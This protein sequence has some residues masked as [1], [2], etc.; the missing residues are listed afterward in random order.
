MAEQE[1]PLRG[2]VRTR[3]HPFAPGEIVARTLANELTKQLGQTV[4]VDNRDGAAGLAPAGTPREVLKKLQQGSLKALKINAVAEHFASNSAV[5]G[6]CAPEEFAAFIAQ[7]QKVW[8]DIVKR[9]GI[10]PD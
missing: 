5:G 9:A 4:Y 7:P 3:S 8:A 1:H 2:A 6:G 10:K